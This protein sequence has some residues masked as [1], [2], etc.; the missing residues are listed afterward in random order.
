MKYF[1]VIILFIPLIMRPMSDEYR[2]ATQQLMSL[3]DLYIQMH[4]DDAA[5]S[6]A[7]VTHDDGSHSTPEAVSRALEVVQGDLPQLND[8]SL[9]GVF[10]SLDN[11]NKIMH[12]YRDEFAGAE[13]TS[14]RLES[15]RVRLPAAAAGV[16]GVAG[17]VNI[18]QQPTKRGLKSFILEKSLLLILVGGAVGVYKAKSLWTQFKFWRLRCK[19]EALEKALAILQPAVKTLE[20]KYTDSLARLHTLEDRFQVL[21]TE[22][23]EH[24]TTFAQQLVDFGGRTKL[25]SDTVEATFAEV[26]GSLSAIQAPVDDL[27]TNQQAIKDQI[28]RIMAKNDEVLAAIRARMAQLDA[29]GKK[30]KK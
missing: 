5:D 15:L 26:R 25:L 12:E 2:E 4:T 23:T 14:A 19:N 20:D 27:R 30:K 1:Y 7:L 17:L 3:G 16:G 22:S 28:G 13:V 29:E 9:E 21:Q 11:V 24:Y 18:M 8:D 10:Q 6:T